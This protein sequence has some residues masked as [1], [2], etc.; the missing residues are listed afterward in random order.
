MTNIDSLQL[1]LLAAISSYTDLAT[2]RKIDFKDEDF[3]DTKY[4]RF[5]QYLT[6]LERQNERIPS[7]VDKEQIW[8]LKLPKDHSDV[9]SLG[10]SLRR[11]SLTVK[12]KETLK[13]AALIVD[14]DPEAAVS[15]LRQSSNLLNA[16]VGGSTHAGFFEEGAED[17]LKEIE[18]RVE[19]RKSGNLIGVP[20]G[21]S[22]FDST[23]LGVQN[24]EFLTIIGKTGL[25][26]SWLLG[27]L[28]V[29]GYLAGNKILYISP[30]MSRFECELRIDVL[31]MNEY[32]LEIS[33]KG[34]LSGQTQ[35]MKVYSEWVD[36][37]TTDREDR[38]ITVDSDKAG[39]FTVGA[40]SDLVNQHR[41][42]ILAI[43]GFH[44]L[45]GNKSGQ[46][47]ESVK[48]NADGLKALCQS[49]QIILYNVTQAQRTVGIHDN[50]S[51]DQVA[52]GVALIEAS[53]K[54]ISLGGVKGMPNRRRLKITKNRIGELPTFRI[55]MDFDVD[56]GVL[57]EIGSEEEEEEEL[58]D[59]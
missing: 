54:I 3:I 50:P 12:T 6:S 19:A 39:G 29:I 28:C 22:V 33:H 26:K 25:G 36:K 38:W 17:R 18:R 30:E 9:F 44:L 55:T 23:G 5:Y 20:T 2:L 15:L 4:R 48:Q 49:K 10:H 34:L 21:L 14:S 7:I 1:A 8:G 40:I 56:R 59:L 24:G 13:D 51:N 58:S 47:W 52:Y 27:K 37:L 45:A 35:Y 41:P 57:Q 42:D 53:D 43:D 46:S 16:S 11:Y 31:M 32:G